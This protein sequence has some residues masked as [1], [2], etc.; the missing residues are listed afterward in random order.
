M[1]FSFAESMIDPSQY[2]PLA[3]AAEK[4]G[5][6]SF[7]IPDSICYP[8]ESDSRYPYTDDGDRQFLDGKPFIEPFTLIPALGAVTERLRFTTFVVKLPIR[9]PVLVAKQA[10]S[11]AVMTGN[12]FGF[13][14]GLSPWPEDFQ[15][16][17]VEW[18][19]RGR[20]MDEMIEIIRGL[21]RGDYYSFH[22]RYYDIPS[23]KLCP[24]PSQPIPILIGGHS[25]AALRRAATIGDGW[26]HGGGGQAADLDAALGRLAELRREAGREREPFEIHVISMDAYTVDGVRKLEDRGVTDCIVG[27]RNAYQAD[28]Q[29][30]QQKLD[31]IA[32]FADNVIA[33]VR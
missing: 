27:F 14:V 19:G 22:G 15:V 8:E 29:P 18:K 9:Q 13:G 32:A 1:R 26:M 4:A 7:V 16:C 31:A 10:T 21:A 20:R 33:K 17:G 28:T 3:M 2:I 24:A 6:D 30:L 23:I 12:R 11:V 5:W 25:D